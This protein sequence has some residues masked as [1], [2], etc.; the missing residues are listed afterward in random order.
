MRETV[1]RQPRQIKADFP[2]GQEQ[3]DHFI[4]PILFIHVE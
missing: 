2:P 4:L 3:L 1:A